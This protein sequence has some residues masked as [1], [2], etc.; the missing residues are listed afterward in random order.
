MDV[1]SYIWLYHV[2]LLAIPAGVRA[3]HRILIF[4]RFSFSVGNVN[5]VENKIWKT[6]A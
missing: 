5:S 2:E 6:S 3:D 4:F 1:V